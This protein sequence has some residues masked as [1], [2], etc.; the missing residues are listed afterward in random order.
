MFVDSIL[1][2]L[3]KEKENKTNIHSHIQKLIDLKNLKRNF[4]SF[5]IICYKLFL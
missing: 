1:L 5:F 3:K 4:P 2:S